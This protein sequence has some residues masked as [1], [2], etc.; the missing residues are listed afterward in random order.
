LRKK[1][2]F[3]SAVSIAFDHPCTA[4]QVK[5]ESPPPEKFRAIMDR[6]ERYFLSK[7]K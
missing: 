4:G 6:S 2:L 5:V 1:G 3:L 7:N